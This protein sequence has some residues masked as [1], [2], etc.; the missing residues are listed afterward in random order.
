MFRKNTNINSL[1]GNHKKGMRERTATG[2]WR[3]GEN[4]THK[5]T[6]SARAAI[7]ALY[8]RTWRMCFQFFLSNADV[9]IHVSSFWWQTLKS[10]ETRH[11]KPRF[12]WPNG[13][14][15]DSSWFP[16][17]KLSSLTGS[18]FCC[19]RTLW[20]GL[21]PNGMQTMI[22]PDDPLHHPNGFMLVHTVPYLNVH[23]QSSD[24]LV[25]LSQRLP[26]ASRQVPP[27]T[28]CR[29]MRIYQSIDHRVHK[30]T[31]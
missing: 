13:R 11:W 21:Y 4:D 1:K 19:S 18:W 16:G 24:I 8:I 27:I 28:H 14:V 26:W 20:D 5:M 9:S 30:Q 15:V 7:W 23:F 3:N 10:T 22:S 25:A 29:S 17:P 12:L 31:P 6:P 2:S